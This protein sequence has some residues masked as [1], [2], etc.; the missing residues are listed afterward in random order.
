M[1]IVSGW[2]RLKAGTRAAFLADSLEAMELA[3]KAPGCQA[4]VVAADPLED[5]LVNVYECWA[6]EADLVAFRDDGPSP[7]MLG[8]IVGANVQRHIIASSGPA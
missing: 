7:E 6:S 4:F 3:R 5:D 2:L 1:I 8:M